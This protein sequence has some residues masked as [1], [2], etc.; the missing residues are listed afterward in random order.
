[1]KPPRRAG[2]VFT[3]REPHDSLDY[4]PTPPWA[5]RALVERVL[6]PRWGALGV[7]GREVDDPACGEGHMAEVLR[8]YASKV[9]ASDIFPYG[10]GAVADYLDGGERPQVD[11]IITNPPFIKAAEFA[12]TALEHSAPGRPRSGVALL[13][14]LG[15]AES[16]QR[17][18]AIF[19]DRPPALIAI[20]SERVAMRRGR[21]D[22]ALKGQTAYAWFVWA[23]EK[24]SGC[25][26]IWIPPGTKAALTR[27]DDA[28]R[29]ARPEPGTAGLFED[30]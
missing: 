2:V 26:T 1:M 10:Y 12:R 4:F 19:G 7:R 24:A 28:A 5:T 11:W 27:P 20:F 17:Y 6:E 8:E 29:F 13:L 21:W 3:R 14:R 18:D 30:A 22:P 23:T 16:E 25:R 15:W 9:Y